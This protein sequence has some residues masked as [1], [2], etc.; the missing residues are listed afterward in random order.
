MAAVTYRLKLDRTDRI[1]RPDAAFTGGVRIR[2]GEV[3]EADLAI[4]EQDAA[5]DETGYDEVEGE[6]PPHRRR[7]FEDDE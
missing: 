5:F 7:P 6:P 4:A 3:V 2:P 1:F